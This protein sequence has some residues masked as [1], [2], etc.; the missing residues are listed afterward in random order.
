MKTGILKS[1]SLALVTFVLFSFDTPIQNEWKILATKD[2]YKIEIDKGAGLD[3]KDVYTIQSLGSKVR[4]FKKLKTKGRLQKS[5]IPTNFLGKRVRLT[6]YMKSKNVDYH[7]AI[8][9]HYGLNDPENNM[10]WLGDFKAMKGTH[11]WTKRELI[12]DVPANAAYIAYGASLQGSGQ[13]WFDCTD[14]EIV[15]SNTPT[16]VKPKRVKQ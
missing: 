13:I 12:F 9:L 2:K 8:I 14:V 16:T 10:F 11:D 6:A 7:A 1:I 4:G 5:I 3:G 15:D